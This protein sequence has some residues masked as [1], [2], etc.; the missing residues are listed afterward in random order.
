VNKLKKSV[1]DTLI[2][3]EEPKNDEEKSRIEEQE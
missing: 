2:S 3:W 1:M